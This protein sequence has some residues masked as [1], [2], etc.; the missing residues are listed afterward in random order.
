MVGGGIA[1]CFTTVNAVILNISVMFVPFI[2][3]V[4]L[5]FQ[6]TKNVVYIRDFLRNDKK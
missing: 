5:R 4:S 3:L 2:A 6:N 1:R